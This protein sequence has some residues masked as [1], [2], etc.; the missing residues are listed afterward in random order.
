MNMNQAL[1]ESGVR[2]DTLSAEEKDFLDLNGYLP[3]GKILTP[4]QIA[5]MIRRL[6]KLAEL[7]GEDAGKELH[8]EGGTIRVSNLVNKGPMFQIGFSHPRVLAAIRHVIGPRFKLSSLDCR[9]ALPGQGH[10]AFH[11]D[12]R[13]GVEPGDYYVCNSM[14]L[15]DDFTVENGATR[16][17]PGSHR[18]GKHP[19]DALED[20]AHK[21]PEEIQLTAASGTVIVFNSHLWHAGGLN[22]TDSPRHGMLAYYCR[23]DHKQL[24]DQR[25][26]IHPKTHARLNE[27]QRFILA[28]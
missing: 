23:R 18:S 9:M 26:F 6:D 16:V 1:L 3:L 19:K 8:Q 17:V 4:E 21:Q 12:W 5:N 22:Q 27:A 2:D 15:L 24:T 25:K 20:A 10:Q 28:V 14:W 13:S 7:E 11:A